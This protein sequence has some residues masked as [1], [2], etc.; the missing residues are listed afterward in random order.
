MSDH[1]SHLNNLV[2]S[3]RAVLSETDAALVRLLAEIPTPEAQGPATSA[4]AKPKVRYDTYD[5]VPPEFRGKMI[6]RDHFSL[7]AQGTC[8]HGCTSCYSR[9]KKTLNKQWVSIV[10]YNSTGPGDIYT[11][12]YCA[13]HA[14]RWHEA[15]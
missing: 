13:K 2:G 11:R 8:T 4:S 7:E 10:V 12:A 1:S 5:S 3:L 6:P 14:A 9:K 15:H